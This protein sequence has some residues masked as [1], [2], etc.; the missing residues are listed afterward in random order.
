MLFEREGPRWPESEAFRRMQRGPNILAE[1]AVD[2]KR[3]DVFE[4]TAENQDQHGDI[5]GTMRKARRR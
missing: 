5:S 1:D 4:G 3:H 2:P